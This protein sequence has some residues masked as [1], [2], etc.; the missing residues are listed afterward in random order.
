MAEE[1]N[2]QRRRFIGAAAMTIAA[3]RLGVIGSG[4]V[5]AGETSPAALPAIKPGANT[6]FGA[7]KQTD[8]GV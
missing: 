7:L 1:I 4:Q 6:S 8:A 5:Q 3:A 2:H